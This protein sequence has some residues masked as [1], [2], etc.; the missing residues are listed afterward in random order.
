MSCSTN[1]TVPDSKN[2][3]GEMKN[4]VFSASYINQLERLCYSQ[5]QRTVGETR[6][7]RATIWAECMDR[8]VNPA[9]QRNR[10][11]QAQQIDLMYKA[12]LSDMRSFYRG[13]TTMKL[14]EQRWINRQ[15]AIGYSKIRTFKDSY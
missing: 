5:I 1:Q 10:P 14:L 6:A 3:I 13:E 2:N 4:G 9:E 8:N 11:D 15:N 12:L 7:G